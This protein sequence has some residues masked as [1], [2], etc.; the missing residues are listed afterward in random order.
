MALSPEAR[1]SL[2]YRAARAHWISSIQ[3]FG[4]ND[5]PEPCGWRWAPL[6]FKLGASWFFRECWKLVALAGDTCQ[7]AEAVTGPYWAAGA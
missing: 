2:R 1:A 3:R 5:F 4:P 7:A 6:Y